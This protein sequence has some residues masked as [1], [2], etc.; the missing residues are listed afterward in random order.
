M[1]EYRSLTEEEIQIL[2]KQGCIAE[3]IGRK[4]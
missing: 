2:E 3:N 4:Y 1:D